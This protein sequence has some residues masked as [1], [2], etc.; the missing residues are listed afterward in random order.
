MVC[1]SSGFRPLK[2]HVSMFSSRRAGGSEETTD[3]P[4]PI[5]QRTVMAPSVIVPTL[6]TFVVTENSLAAATL[7]GP[8]WLNETAR[9]G[10]R[11][12]GVIG[13]GDGTFACEES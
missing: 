10:G 7:R 4:L 13:S 12:G 9:I 8:V 1:D 11:G 6:V 2:D 5:S 3:M